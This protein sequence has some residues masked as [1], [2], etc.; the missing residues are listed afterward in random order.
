M[1]TRREH[2]TA[3]KPSVAR[4]R[5]TATGTP[6]GWS[7]RAVDRALQAGQRRSE[8][9]AVELRPGGSVRYILCWRQ[10]PE[11]L[12]TPGTKRA[13]DTRKQSV[14]GRR[15]ATSEEPPEAA[16]KSE[17]ETA[18]TDNMAVDAGQEI[19]K[20]KQ[21]SQQ[22]L[23]SHGKAMAFVKSLIFKRWREAV[24]QE[25]QQREQQRRDEAAAA[26]AAEAAAAAQAAEERARRHELVKLKRQL[27][28]TR[29]ML[30][31]SEARALEAA[32]HSC[33]GRQSRRGSG[34]ESAAREAA[35]RRGPPPRSGSSLSPSARR[36][37][38]RAG[39]RARVLLQ[40]E[41]RAL[42]LAAAATAERPQPLL[43]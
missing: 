12:G 22:R 27:A 38:T 17:G 41:A 11:R 6:A 10:G 21:R 25:K 20:A 24:Q 5:R 40:E 4:A 14:D 29:E 18:D 32:Q 16:G 13:N 19:S 42:A 26:A 39:A 43:P 28:D 34:R 2:R 31:I 35:T 3:A 30:A 36:R 9:H 23:A 1:A 7:R 8:V 15:I 33:N 37:R